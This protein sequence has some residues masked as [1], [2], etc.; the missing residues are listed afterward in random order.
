MI[1]V[2][3][4]SDFRYSCADRSRDE[5]FRDNYERR[6]YQV[7]KCGY[8]SEIS[9]PYRPVGDVELDTK[10]LLLKTLNQA[11]FGF[12]E[13]EK[14]IQKEEHRR[15]L[16]KT[17]NR[18]SL[19]LKDTQE[20]REPYSRTAETIIRRELREGRI[21][22]APFNVNNT[23]AMATGVVTMG[24]ELLKF[25][26]KS[27][28]SLRY[29][30]TNGHFDDVHLQLIIETSAPIGWIIHPASPGGSFRPFQHWH[31]KSHSKIST[32]F[33]R[34]FQKCKRELY[35]F[36]PIECFMKEQSVA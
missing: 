20:K 32:N 13:G 30:L 31:V 26:Q 12:L 23:V 8:W 29:S 36:V 22:F 19:K 1:N 15:R 34:K 27:S 35:S 16:P 2:I 7:K 3:T 10:A 18:N 25:I 17:R 33:R 24:T 6:Q 14:C 5:I 4:T 28:L 11:D 9:R 21:L